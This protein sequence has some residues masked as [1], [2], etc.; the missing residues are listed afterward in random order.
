VS[1]GD[2]GGGAEQVGGEQLAWKLAI[3]QSQTGDLTA[4]DAEGAKKEKMAAK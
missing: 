2:R 1:G 3:S 4:K